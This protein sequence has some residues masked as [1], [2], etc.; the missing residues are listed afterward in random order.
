MTILLID[1]HIAWVGCDI[2][3]DNWLLSRSRQGKS[4]ARVRLREGRVGEWITVVWVTVG[5]G[6][7]S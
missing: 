5:S 2:S 4:P 7:G 1:D 3:I 6:Y